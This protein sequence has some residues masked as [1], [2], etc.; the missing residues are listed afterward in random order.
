[1][2]CRQI[3]HVCIC[4]IHSAHTTKCLHGYNKIFRCS[5]KHIQQTNVSQSVEENAVDVIGADVSANVSSSS[6]CLWATGNASSSSS[7]SSRLSSPMYTK[8]WKNQC[9]RGSGRFF[10][11]CQ[12]KEG[13]CSHLCLKQKKS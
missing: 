13:R 5:D 10:L 2:R 6:S 12:P 11:L 7:G 4:W 3:G 9:S 8:S 1:M